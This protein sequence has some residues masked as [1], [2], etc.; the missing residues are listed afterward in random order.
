[1]RPLSAIQL[2][3]VEFHRQLA[4]H[5]G[6]Q[7]FFQASNQQRVRALLCELAKST[8]AK[9]L[10]DVGC[11]TG[12]IL[13]LAHDLFDELDGIDITPEMLEKVTPRPNVKTQLASAQALPFPDG[14]FDMVTAYGVLHHIEELSRVFREVRRTL[15][16]GG[17]F[18]ADESPSQHYTD[19]I[20]AL[21][22]KSQMA[23]TVRRE[24]DRLLC[25]SSE[26][27]R[28]YEIQPEV[29][30]RA[31]AQNYFRHG[32]RQ[33]NLNRLLRAAGFVSIEFTYRRFLGE[34]LCRQEGG[35]ALVSAMQR[36]LVSLWPLTRGLF[37]YFVIV[38]R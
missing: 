2:A 11:G 16:P 9:R 12:L 19:T 30:Q 27:Q 37:K 35:E 31:M 24:Q 32:L 25:D 7:P 17:I 36:H 23:D 28:L 21:N 13:D 6:L 18:Y 26:Y 10:L 15:R 38:A 1:M 20:M 34:D 8:P 14:A 29:V 33:E 3:N 5:Y 22:P 4:P